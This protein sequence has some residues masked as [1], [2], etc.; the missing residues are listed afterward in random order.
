MFGELKIF[1][2]YF[3]PFHYCTRVLRIILL[4]F[5]VVKQINNYDDH[6]GK[7]RAL[8]GGFFMRSEKGH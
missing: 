6:H 3:D 1:I 8:R 2:S 7:T 4:L 5:I